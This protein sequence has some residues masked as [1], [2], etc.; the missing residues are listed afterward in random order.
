[1][2]FDP[3]GNFETKGYL[4]N[5]AREKDRDILRRLEHSAFTTALDESL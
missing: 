1:V 5:A 2:T 3:F 4:R